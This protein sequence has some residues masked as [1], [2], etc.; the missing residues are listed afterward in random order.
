MCPLLTAA[1]LNPCCVESLSTHQRLRWSLLSL[2]ESSPITQ[3]IATIFLP[4]LIAPGALFLNKQMILGM[5]FCLPRHSCNLS[6][7]EIPGMAENL[8][9]QLLQVVSYL[10]HRDCCRCGNDL[11]GNDKFEFKCENGPF[12]C[13]HISRNYCWEVAAFLCCRHSLNSYEVNF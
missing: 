10:L 9:G 4:P 7:L 11:C 2:L 13:E 3:L 12:T 6:L 8:L 1:T 5:W